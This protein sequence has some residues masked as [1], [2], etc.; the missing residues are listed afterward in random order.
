MWASSNEE[1]STLEGLVAA[2]VDYLYNSGCTEYSG[3]DWVMHCDTE[4]FF[5]DNELAL[6]NNII[7][8]ELDLK[9]ENEGYPISCCDYSYSEY[10]N[11]MTGEPLY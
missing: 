9:I 10:Y 6:F 1:N 5:L 3:A 11:S 2:T 4:D 7:Q 8:D